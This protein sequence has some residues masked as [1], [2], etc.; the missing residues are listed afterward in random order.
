MNYQY[1]PLI[2]LK[3]FIKFIIKEIMEWRWSFDSTTRNKLHKVIFQ[4]FYSTGILIIS[5]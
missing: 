1:P 5:I 3:S 2:E 4:N